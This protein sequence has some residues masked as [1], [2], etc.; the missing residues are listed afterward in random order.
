MKAKTLLLMAAYMFLASCFTARVFSQTLT[1]EQVIREV[2]TNSDSV[3]M[4]KES[5]KKA[6]ELVRQNWANALP[7]ISASGAAIHNYGS[8]FGSSSS[9]SGSS[10]SLAKQTSTFTPMDS[11]LLSNIGDMLSSFS[12]ISKPVNSNIYTA[13]ISFNQP[14]YTFGKVGKAIEVANQ[15]KKSSTESY[16]R[17]MQTL[18][19]T[20]LD[21]FFD[22]VL[23]SK[24]AEISDHTLDRKKELYA[25]LKRNFDLGS[26][27]K[28]QVLSTKADVASEVSNG[29]ILR[30][31]ALTA[32]MNLNFFIGAALTDATPLDTVVMLPNL[33][34]PQAMTAE[35]GVSTALSNRA[36]LKG[37]KLIAEANKNGAKIYRAMYLPTIGATGSAGYGKMTSELSL[38]STNGNPNWS[39]G[40]GASWTLFDGFTNSAKANQLQ[41]DANKYEIL[42][43]SLEKAIEINVRSWIAECVAQDTNYSASKEKLESARQ[44]YELTNS[45]FKQGSGQFADLKQADEQLQ[46]AER[47]MTLAFYLLVRSRAGLLVAMGKEIINIDK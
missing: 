13:G 21:M 36:D 12:D 39:L 30:R 19:L 14:I 37:L 16:S 6:N 38:F 8:A 24:A 35:E 25:Y 5:V 17:N 1:L 11:G 10:R 20:A 3:K 33:M 47:G 41:S 22:A 34:A 23:K 4:M 28:A 9:G 44:S 26:G 31:D 27:N 40:I 18:Q 7:V 32:R 15:Y 42:Y 2:C 43:N 29:I 45:N 46:Q